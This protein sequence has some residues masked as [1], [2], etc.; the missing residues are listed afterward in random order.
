MHDRRPPGV[1]R[2]PGR[3]Q[4]LRWRSSQSPRL[5]HPAPHTMD[6]EIAAQQL[7]TTANGRLRATQL[8]IL[9]TEVLRQ[10]DAQDGVEDSIIS[11]SDQY[12]FD[13]SRIICFCPSHCLTRTQADTAG[14]ILGDYIVKSDGRTGQFTTASPSARFE[15]H[16][17]VYFDPDASLAKYEF[18][19]ER[20][21]LDNFTSTK[22]PLHLAKIPGPKSCW[23][24][25][26]QTR[27]KLPPTTSMPFH[28]TEITVGKI[29]MYY[30]RADGL[31]CPKALLAYYN[32]AIS[33]M[34][35]SSKETRSWL[36]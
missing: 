23:T 35:I 8:S 33:S 25:N 21:F 11:Q 36:P 20:Y 15:E 4:Q 16:W 3:R 6:L 27:A 17:F 5:G 32:T 14:N 10:Y 12:H 2:D 28:F 9:V 13:M 7:I 29:I 34:N 31:I 19:Y 1:E 30:G 26:R 22:T 18:S 24:Q